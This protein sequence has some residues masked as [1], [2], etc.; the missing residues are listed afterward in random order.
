M[1]IY[2]EQSA[3]SSGVFARCKGRD[4]KKIFEVVLTPDK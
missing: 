3:Q 2:Y 4:C 1:P